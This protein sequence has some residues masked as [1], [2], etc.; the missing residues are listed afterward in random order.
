MA[1]R[2]SI[3]Q[4]AIRALDGAPPRRPHAVSAR[5][6]ARWAC[7]LLAWLLVA[8]G[9]SVNAAAQA[10]NS[11]VGTRRAAERTSFSDGEIRDGFM[12]TAFRAELQFDRAVERIRKF[13]GPVRVFV[14][15]RAAPGRSAQIA[16][17]VAD[18]R[19]R[20][21]RLDLTMT[22]D[23]Q[24]ANVIVTLVR[25]R[26]V[27][28]TIRSHFGP[29]KARRIQ[30]SLEPQCLVGIAKDSSYRIQRAEVI[31][32]TDVGDFRFLDCAYEEL[33]QAL[34][35]LNDDNSVPWTMF[36]DDVQMGYFDVYDQYL[37]NILYDERVRPGMTKPEV[38]RL[39]PE[40]LPAVRD[41]VGEIN[42]LGAAT[43]GEA[44]GAALDASCN[45]AAGIGP[46][47]NRQ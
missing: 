41:W 46:D 47:R 14:A 11:D 40:I 35:F 36:N 22:Q 12:K 31:L 4:P 6:P 7:G 19:S 27:T 23:R 24:A 18:I 39:L 29:D 25:G 9:W 5:L 16:A 38:G 32:P 10:Q 15:D 43:T 3:N 2:V 17:V 1:L 42:P 21:K 26:D 45:C 8:T 37:V 28:S 20:V 33:L 34:G 44:S 13:D 30:R